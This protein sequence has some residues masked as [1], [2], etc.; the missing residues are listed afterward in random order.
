MRKMKEVNKLAVM[1][2]STDTI[3]IYQTA[4]NLEVTDEYV[5]NL[6]FSMSTCHY[7]TGKVSIVEHKDI[8]T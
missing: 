2:W 8:L 6:G 1:D 5:E 3:H 4:P 7:M